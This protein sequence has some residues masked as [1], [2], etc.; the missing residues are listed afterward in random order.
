MKKAFTLI[1]VIISIVII[2]IAI[3]AI[4]SVMKQTQK[5]SDLA[6]AQES[7]LATTTKLYSIYSYRWDEKSGDTVEDPTVV[8]IANVS[9]SADPELSDTGDGSR[10][11]HVIADGRN[12][13]FTVSGDHNASLVANFGAG[14][15]LNEDGITPEIDFDDIDDFHGTSFNLTTGALDTGGIGNVDYKRGLEMNATVGYVSDNVDYSTSNLALTFA[16]APLAD[17]IQTTNIK[18]IEVRATAKV[19]DEN[20]TFLL[21]GY[22][23]NIGESP[24]YHRRK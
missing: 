9:D 21:R 14:V 22:A 7:I 16:T 24:L 15:D 13:F 1:E 17:V 19:L 10:V 12:K 6:I 20:I 3:S 5:S 18:M 2:A 4:P 8:R 11:G 23:T